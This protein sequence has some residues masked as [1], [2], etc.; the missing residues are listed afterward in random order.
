MK[1]VAVDG[2]AIAWESIGADDA[3]AVVLVH[4]LGLDMRLWDPQVPALSEAHRVVRLDLRGHGSSDCPPGPY[5]VERLSRDVLAVADG[6]GVDR[7]H[8][9]GQSLG[10]QVA[11]WLA[12]HH[13]DRLRSV[14]YCNTAPKIGDKAM[15][16]AR[17]A[18]VREGGLASI[19]DAWL[20]RVFSPSTARE[21][22]ELLEAVGETF[23]RTDPE[24]YTGCCR[25][26][27]DADLWPLVGRHDLPSLI[28][29]GAEDPVIPPDESRRLH[30]RIPGSRLVVL[31]GAAHVSNVERPDEFSSVLREFLEE[32]P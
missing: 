14:I 10:G 1:R 30:Q 18:A 8:L 11:L 28:I 22:P 25:A 29:A 17:V 13:P 19:R 15:W 2:T 5:S 26:I 24:G 9:C 16:E 12:A 4:S 31:E 3:P 6:A 7:F 20:E 23:V 27:A 21:R 32:R